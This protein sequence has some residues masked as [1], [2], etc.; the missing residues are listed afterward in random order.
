MINRD[1]IMEFIRSLEYDIT[2]DTL[3]DDD[4]MEVIITIAQSINH[5]C[6]YLISRAI[7][8]WEERN[9]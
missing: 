1:D 3:S 8:T 2:T 7:R 9:K 5:D 6:E 4:K